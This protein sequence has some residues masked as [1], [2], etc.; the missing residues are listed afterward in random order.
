MLQTLL[1][2]GEYLVTFAVCLGMLHMYLRVEAWR[3]RRY[4]ERMRAKGWYFGS[5]PDM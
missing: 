5:T 4:R 1:T 2:I 3:H